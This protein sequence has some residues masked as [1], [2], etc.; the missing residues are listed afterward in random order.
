M[1]GLGRYDTDQ[2]SLYE[3]QARLHH[4][5]EI[6]RAHTDRGEHKVDHSVTQKHLDFL[7][8]NPELLS[9]NPPGFGKPEGA[10][11]G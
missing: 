10:K 2:M 3:Y 9:A 5:N 11:L 1:M 6:H 8:S 7:R 4:W